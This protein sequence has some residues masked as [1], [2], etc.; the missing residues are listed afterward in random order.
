MPL[1]RKS[2]GGNNVVQRPLQSNN[3][4]SMSSLQPDVTRPQPSPPNTS[5][6]ARLPSTNR[7]VTELG[8]RLF[9]LIYKFP[10]GVY[11]GKKDFRIGIAF[12]DGLVEEFEA[13]PDVPRRWGSRMFAKRKFIDVDE[14]HL[15]VVGVAPAP[16]MIYKESRDGLQESAFQVFCFCAYLHIMMSPATP[17]DTTDDLRR[18]YTNYAYGR[19]GVLVAQQ[20]E[21]GCNT[22]A[23]NSSTSERVRVAKAPKE[24]VDG[25]AA[26]EE[27][28]DCLRDGCVFGG[29][30]GNLHPNALTPYF[31]ALAKRQMEGRMQSIDREVKAII[32]NYTAE[33]EQA[34]AFAL[35]Q[36]EVFKFGDQYSFYFEKANAQ[37][38]AELVSAQ[39]NTLIAKQSGGR[40]KK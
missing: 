25:R 35:A 23:R 14:I 38:K 39:L 8:P 10:E 19:F 2:V 12:K 28:V 16:F 40:K 31:A 1:H 5:N 11:C 30:G 37:D 36:A 29:K 7:T 9:D 26:W 3:A 13:A 17:A 33:V 27:V 20:F 15:H 4:K 32:Q 24:L 21:P 6:N 22:N 34:L 18:N